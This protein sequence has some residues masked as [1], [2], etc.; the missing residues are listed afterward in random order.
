M[1]GIEAKSVMPVHPAKQPFLLEE[2][3]AMDAMPI[4]AVFI[5]S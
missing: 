2:A 3:V 1:S 4:S 5:L